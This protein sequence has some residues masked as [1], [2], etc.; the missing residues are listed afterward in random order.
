MTPKCGCID[1]KYA[2]SSYH[3]RIGLG[4]WTH[5]PTLVWKNMH[6]HSVHEYT[7]TCIHFWS[8]AWR[9][10]KKDPN[11]A[12]DASWASSYSCI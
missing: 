12:R 4:K 8:H 3:T 2:N 1:V 6:V 5:D 9:W 11:P 7:D 10:S